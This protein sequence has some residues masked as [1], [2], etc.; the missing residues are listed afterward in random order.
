MQVPSAG[1]TSLGQARV[2]KV[3][4]RNDLALAHWRTG[5]RHDC[6]ERFDSLNKELIRLRLA[7]GLA[8]RRNELT[9]ICI[10]DACGGQ[11]CLRLQTELIFCCGCIDPAGTSASSCL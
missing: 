7:F 3:I 10:G 5:L 11:V 4:G 9:A 1:G 8:V 2:G 6:G